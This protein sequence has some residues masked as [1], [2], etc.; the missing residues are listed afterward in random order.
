MNRGPFGCGESPPAADVG[1]GVGPPRCG[2]GRASIGSPLVFSPGSAFVVDVFEEVEGEMRVDRWRTLARRYLPWAALGLLLGLLVAG[3]VW[4]WREWR[5]TGA[6]QASLAYAD[7]VEAMGEGD[8]RAAEVKFRQVAAGRSDAYR[9][10]AEMQLGGL[11]LTAGKPGEAAAAFDRAADVAPDPLVGDAARLKAVFARMDSQPYPTSVAQ[12]TPLAEEGRPYRLLALEALALARIGAGQGRA[13]RADLGVLAI[14]PTAPD[15]TR[16]RA[17]AL[18]ALLDSG[19]AAS[20]PTVAKA[21]AALPARPAAPASLPPG[22]VPGGAAP[23]S[24]SAPA[25]APTPG[26]AQP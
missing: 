5:T 23:A 6:E 17:E 4:G 25:A 11:R 14:A 20:L 9:A 2:H 18:I 21:A 13:A 24:P 8:S 7:G 22:L 15:S 1:A 26:T 16:R 12:L 19:A 3:G 10:L